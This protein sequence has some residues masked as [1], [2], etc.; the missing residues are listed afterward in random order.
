[1]TSYGSFRNYCRYIAD[2]S[3]IAKP[4][5][6]LLKDNHSESVST[7]QTPN[8]A[9]KPNL[10]QAPSRK[11]VQ[12]TELHKKTLSTL[13]DALTGPPVMPIQN[14]TSRLLCIQMHLKNG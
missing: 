3:R 2:F 6:D 12:W 13:I 1:M 5:Y 9:K 14:L 10:N 8:Q 4:I 7:L 11:H